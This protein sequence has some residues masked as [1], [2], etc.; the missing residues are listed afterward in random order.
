MTKDKELVLS[1][2]KMRAGFGA[3]LVSGYSDVIESKDFAEFEAF[4]AEV[5]FWG[6]NCLSEVWT[7]EL[8]KSLWRI[9]DV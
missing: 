7:V 4:A 5:R 3:T 6:L 8:C 9:I 1:E 2:K